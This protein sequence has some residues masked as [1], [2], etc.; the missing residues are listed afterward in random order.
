MLGSQDS[1]SQAASP[2]FFDDVFC[3]RTVGVIVATGVA[4]VT[5]V[6][7]EML[8]VAR[9]RRVAGN[10]ATKPPSQ[11]HTHHHPTS[12]VPM[13]SHGPIDMMFSALYK[14][15]F[16]KRVLSSLPKIPRTFQDWFSRG[17]SN[18]GQILFFVGSH[19]FSTNSLLKQMQYKIQGGT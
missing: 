17:Y 11:H 12:T 1:S 6:V 13:K 19:T 5:G 2:G 7:W 18:L 3:S 10:Q 9:V 14:T 16:T 8:A 4:F 15:D